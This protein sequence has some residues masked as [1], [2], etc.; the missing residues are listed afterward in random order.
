LGNQSI[1]RRN[2]WKT[3]SL[4]RWTAKRREKGELKTDGSDRAGET[5]AVNGKQARAAGR[6]T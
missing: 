3:G 5:G 1:G 4:D 2:S 6:A